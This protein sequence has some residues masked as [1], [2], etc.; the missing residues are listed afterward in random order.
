MIIGDV[1]DAIVVAEGIE[2]ALSAGRALNMPA[3]ATLG[4]S[5]LMKLEVPDTIR[6][7][8]IAPDRDKGGTGERHARAL[9]ERLAQRGLSVALAWAPDDLGDWNEY[10]MRKA[11]GIKEA[12]YA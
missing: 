10:D 7:I 8:I 2:S 9:G 6:R 4:A 1:S 12:T 3:I 11:A 5:N